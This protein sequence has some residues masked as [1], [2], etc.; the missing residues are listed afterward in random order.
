M[1]GLWKKYEEKIKAKRDMNTKR[2]AESK[3]E[4]AKKSEA[5]GLS[6]AVEGK[7]QK[8]SR[9]GSHKFIPYKKSD[10]TDFIPSRGNKSACFHT[11]AKEWM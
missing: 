4:N 7:A 9:I 2:K 10:L 6:S 1:L 3:A 11:S 8:Y 5:T